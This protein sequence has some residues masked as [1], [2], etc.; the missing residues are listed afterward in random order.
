MEAAGRFSGVGG[1]PPSPSNDQPA[2]LRRNSCVVDATEGDAP[3][4][5]EG[6]AGP[7]AAAAASG[8]GNE[9]A[10]SGSPRIDPLALLAFSVS[11]AALP[12]HVLAAALPFPRSASPRHGGAAATA[13]GGAAVSRRARL[14]AAALAAEARVISSERSARAEGGGAEGVGYLACT[15]TASS[16]RPHPAAM[17]RRPHA[18]PPPLPA[19]AP[20]AAAWRRSSVLELAR[21]IVHVRDVGRS[22]K[23]PE[24]SPLPA[25]RRTLDLP[26]AWRV[27]PV[28]D[29]GPSWPTQDHG[30]GG[31]TD[32]AA[33]RPLPGAGAP[34]VSP[35]ARHR[36]ST[37]EAVVGLARRQFASTGG[38]V[39]GTGGGVATDTVR[40]PA[41][42]GRDNR[43]L[44][45]APHRLMQR[46][47]AAQRGMRPQK[48][49]LLP[50]GDAVA[51][52]SPMAPSSPPA[53]PPHRWGFLAFS[54]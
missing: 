31:G 40:G 38:G 29:A 54:Q 14:A 8:R 44:A 32:A 4:E 19:S 6:A 10:E 24:F 50:Q 35:G 13:T 37:V 49:R 52:A 22:H 27:F 45:S 36:Q 28:P 12:A 16:P 41:K 18:P 33:P 39:R 42:R 23:A 53:A 5:P 1:G 34:I 9:A 25:R 51:A 2:S 17:F 20:A 30:A 46:P 3:I 21:T 7:A 11:P 47:Q 15:V 26:A 43:A 48:P